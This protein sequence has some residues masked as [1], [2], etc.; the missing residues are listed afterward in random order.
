MNSNQESLQ[1]IDET[2]FYDDLFERLRNGEQSLEGEAPID[3]DIFYENIIEQLQDNQEEIAK[4]AKSYLIDFFI[5]KSKPKHFIELFE[6]IAKEDYLNE[7]L[8]DV[9]ISRAFEA[10]LICAGNKID[11][12]NNERIKTILKTIGNYFVDNFN[13][14]IENEF[15][16][17]ILRSFILIIGNKNPF[18]TNNKELSSSNIKKKQKEQLSFNLKSVNKLKELPDDWKLK[19]FLKK[20]YELLDKDKILEMTLINY[21]S[22]MIILFMHNLNSIYP[23]LS[24][25]LIKSIHKK[26]KIKENSFHSMIQ[27]VVGSRFIEAFL[28][29]CNSKIREHY[30]EKFLLPNISAYSV[31]LYANYVLQSLLRSLNDD[32]QVSL[33]LRIAG[34]KLKYTLYF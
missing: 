16:I 17:Y 23:E 34:F 30:F 12:L 9:R 11:T 26:M 27:D 15:A 5:Y 13:E 14:I 10:F 7:Y 8:K 20:F 22:P 21:K 32:T 3:N 6:L 19:K 1:K 28:C 31:H 29:L 4:C 25:E 2:R 33:L 24:E 18:D